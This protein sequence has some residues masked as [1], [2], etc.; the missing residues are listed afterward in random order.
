VGSTVFNG[1]IKLSAGQTN[2]SFTSINVTL[3]AGSTIDFS[4]GCGSDSA[5]S[6]DNTGINA[7]IELKKKSKKGL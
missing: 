3:I 4:V 5:W 1:A 6:Y 7:V 2:V